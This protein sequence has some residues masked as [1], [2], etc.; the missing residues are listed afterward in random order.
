MLSR[1]RTTRPGR[2]HECRGV[3]PREVSTLP[4]PRRMFS[5]IRDY[6]HL[7]LDCVIP[8]VFSSSTASPKHGGVRPRMHIVYASLAVS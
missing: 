1:D 5:I 2:D 7:Q 3:P 6:D 8:W 4:R